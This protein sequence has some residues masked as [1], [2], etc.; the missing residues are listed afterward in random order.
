[1]PND[2]LKVINF[3][4]Y[5]KR[6]MYQPGGIACAFDATIQMRFLREGLDNFGRWIWQEFGTQRM[7]TRIYTIYRVCDGNEL[8]SGTS[9]AWF[10]Q[11]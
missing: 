9:T 5:P 10:Q 8:I 6:S 7:I 3:P 4:S 2:R 11:K 1:M